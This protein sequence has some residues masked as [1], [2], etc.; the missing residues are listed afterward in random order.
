MDASSKSSRK[1]LF[2]IDKHFI[3]IN[4]V[5]ALLLVMNALQLFSTEKHVLRDVWQESNIG[6]RTQI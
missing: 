6:T 4:S 5:S 3:I 1:I 2:V